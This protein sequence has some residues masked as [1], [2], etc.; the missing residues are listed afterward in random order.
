MTSK[1]LDLFKIIGSM[2]IA[3]AALLVSGCSGPYDSTVTGV[4]RYDGQPLELGTVTFHPAAGAAA[5]GQ[6]S[7]DG[8]YTIRTGEY[9]GIVSGEYR[10]TVSSM[11]KIPADSPQDP[12]STETLIPLKYKNPVNS[13]LSF[14]VNPGANQIDIDLPKS[15]S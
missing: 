6:I 3:T 14:T 4:V 12:P 11:K 9:N 1:P 5:Y 7:S 13:G 10:V 8:S 15:D 2:G